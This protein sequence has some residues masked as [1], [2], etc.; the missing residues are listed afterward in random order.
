MG[1]KVQVGGLSLDRGETFPPS[2]PGKR[3]LER[4]ALLEGCGSG[5]TRHTILSKGAR[6][7]GRAVR[8]PRGGCRIQ[9]VE[10]L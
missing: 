10:G 4:E 8:V 2:Q 6:R 1:I 3:R 5:K 9:K 7:I